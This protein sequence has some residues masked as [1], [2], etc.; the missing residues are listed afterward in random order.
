MVIAV[1]MEGFSGAKLYYISCNIEI[2]V[3]VLHVYSWTL[4]GIPDLR[5]VVCTTGEEIFLKPGVGVPGDGRRIGIVEPMICHGVRGKTGG[6]G[7]DHPDR[8][9]VIGKIW[10][11]EGKRKVDVNIVIELKKSLFVELHESSA[12][13]SLGDRGD[14]VDG[15]G[16]R[17]FV[18]L[19]VREAVCF[20]PD[21]GGIMDETSGHAW[22]VADS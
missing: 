1:F 14:D 4:G 7:K 15:L 10:I 18:C 19:K 2:D 5:G 11:P 6:M 22:I 3:G 13:D 12:G 8:N 21:D 20:L 17:W 16:G 9:R